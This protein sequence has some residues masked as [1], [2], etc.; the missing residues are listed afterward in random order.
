MTQ[1][2]ADVYPY[3]TSYEPL[4]NVPIVS[5]ATVWTCPTT[6]ETYI[7]IF[8]ESLYYGTK[9]DHTLLNPNQIRHNGVDFWDNPY[10]K[11][12]RLSIQVDGGPIIPLEFHGTKLQFESR[13]PTKQ[14]LE[15]CEHVEVTSD[16]IWEPSEVQL[17]QMDSHRKKRRKSLK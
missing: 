6:R 17:G 16:L 2:T 5:G 11:E 12:E 14:E 13:V 1:R 3:D 10:N 7:L 8:N 4:L 15:E 9:L